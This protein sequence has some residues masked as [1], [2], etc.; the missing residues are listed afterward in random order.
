MRAIIILHFTIARGDGSMWVFDWLENMYI[1]ILTALH[2]YDACTLQH[3]HWV[4]T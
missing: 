4:C 3:G 2:R 1:V